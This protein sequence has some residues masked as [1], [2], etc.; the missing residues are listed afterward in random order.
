MPRGLVTLARAWLVGVA[1]RVVQLALALWLDPSL[2]VLLALGL[3]V[4]GADDARVLRAGLAEGAA[5]RLH[6][7]AHGDRAADRSLRDR[8]RLVVAGLPRPP[9]GLFWF[10][11]VSYFNGLVVEIGRKTRAP[12]DEEHGVETY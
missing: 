11:L 5:G 10:L 8:V 9:H 4:P 1:P 6:G 3:G 2:V 12:A 7:V